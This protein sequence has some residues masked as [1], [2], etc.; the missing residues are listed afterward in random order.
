MAGQNIASTE[1]V[2][3]DGCTSLRWS[4]MFHISIDLMYMLMGI[5]FSHIDSSCYF[6][7]F[8]LLSG[9]LN[10]GGAHIIKLICLIL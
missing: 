2:Y 3:A 10:N 4:T 1:L 6:N 5:Q 7:H 8:F 9:F